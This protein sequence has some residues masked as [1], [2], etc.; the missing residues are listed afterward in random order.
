MSQF[1]WIP[2]YMEIADKLV[3]YESKQ[4]ELLEI[5]RKMQ[6]QGLKVISLTDKNERNE[7][8]PLDV[9]DPFTF[10]AN[11]NRGIT[12]QNRKDILVSL[13]ETFGL[14]SQIPQDFDG[15]PVMNN[16]STWFFS[17]KKNRQASDISR[18]WNIFKEAHAQKITPETFNAVLEV[19]NVK[20]NLTMGI[21]WI[22]PKLYLNLD[23]TNREYLKTFGI[24]LKEPLNHENYFAYLEETKQKQQKPFYEISHDAYLHSRGTK[25]PPKVAT[26]DINYWLYSPGEG[27]QYWE[28]FYQQC[29]MCIGW[30][31]L[32]DLTQYKAKKAIADAIRKHSNEIDSSKKNDTHACYSFA[33]TIKPGDI[34]LAKS[35]VSQILGWGIVESDYFFDDTRPDFRHVRKIAWQAKGYWQVDDDRHF[36]LKT[37]TNIT[38]YRDFVEYLKGVVGI[39]K[40][41][42]GPTQTI[43]NFW[44][45]N[46]NPKIWSFNNIK[47]GES[48]L[49]TSHNTQGNK[50]RV[51]KYF[52]ETK[53]GDI[54]VGYCSS[55]EKQIVGMCKISKGLH[56]SVEG[57]AIE[58]TKVEH[59]GFPIEIATLQKIP[60]LKSSEP[61][62]NNQGSLFKLTPAEYE[63]VRSV[64]DE[65][66]TQH[67]ETKE[68]YSHQHALEELFV[69]Q[70]DLV[71]IL[72]RLET[73]KNIILQGPPGVGKTFIAKRLAYA[74]MGVKDN[75]RVAMIQF[76]QS[77]S[78]ED[79]MQGYRPN[80][81]GFVLQN[82]VFFQF[83]KQAQNNPNKKYFFII[84]E[85]NRGNL[86]KIFGELMLLIEADKRGPDFAVPLTYAETLNDT[87][88]IPENLHII[89]TMNTA[90]RSL[91]MVDY[92]L[93]RRFSFIDL[94]PAF[95]TKKFTE[96]LL[97][98]GAPETIVE[99]ITD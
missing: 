86:S 53:P 56:E 57:E 41:S 51:Y 36:A 79:F 81:G 13:K 37:L 63:I 91:A 93:R 55:P 24:A 89:G 22:N 58:L 60:D 12:E 40:Q 26:S 98:R 90:D 66:N 16:Q 27:A 94:E 75:N 33:H 85:I 45:M 3:S 20:Y 19:R 50:R 1:S 44:W 80:D 64:I 97:S 82:G 42:S 99:A 9:I 7:E 71:Y 31:Y 14:Q 48:I 65:L 4:Q 46:A 61:I 25:E 15:I 54:V 21:Y 83:C 59:L 62:V 78:Y 72:K 11:W 68:S 87:F 88:W 38:Q 92:A 34:V 35:G 47:I 18:L 23:N 69:K 2:I 95:G 5:L 70:E 28:E 96:H 77:Y 76:H 8:V 17:Y 6:D 39:D 32:G 30:D 84:D 52:Q 67:V 29:I 10:Y 73:K 49:Y 43:E 74:L